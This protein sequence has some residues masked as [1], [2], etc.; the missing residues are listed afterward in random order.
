VPR[1][2]R[3]QPATASVSIGWGRPA[4]GGALR[5]VRL[6]LCDADDC[7]FATEAAA[8]VPSTAVTN[9]LLADLGVA[10]RFAPDELRA[11]AAG[12]NFRAMATALAA[13]HGARLDPAE[14][15]RRVAEER[16]RVI[17]HLA[18][19]LAPD[20]AVLEPLA[21][22][23]ERFALA[24]VSSSALA[25]LDACFAAAG[26]AELLP[27]SVRFSAEDSLAEPRSKPDP[28]VYRAAG[29]RLG[30]AGPE[31][32]AVEDSLSG[33]SSAVAAGFPV[34]GN[35]MFVPPAERDARAAA[36]R[37]RGAVAI[38]AS[39]WELAALLGVTPSR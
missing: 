4:A 17:A 33:V 7:L 31:A 15:E 20:P 27:P 39:W 36:L 12:R 24:V 13:E 3:S 10:R 14:L 35:L 28:A 16:G 32:L 22:L 11:A 2:R 34:V 18:E 1:S 9:D 37:E 6:L 8:F 21:A 38:V 23:A 26:L 30:V 25:R 5:D 29:E 19:V